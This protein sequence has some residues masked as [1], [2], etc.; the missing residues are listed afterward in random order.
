MKN[1]V[2][3][4]ILSF[5]LCIVVLEV[6]FIGWA[7]FRRTTVQ[8]PRTPISIRATRTRFPR[9]TPAS[10][11]YQFPPPSATPIRIG[12]LNIAEQGTLREKAQQ[13]LAPSPQEALAAAKKLAFA[14]INSHPSNMCGPLAIA[15][16]RDSRLLPPDT[17]LEKFWLLNP[18]QPAAKQLL[19]QYFPADR[20]EHITITT[21]LN[22]TD[23][24]LHPLYPGD[25]IYIYAGKGGN[26]EH[27]L[28][29]TRVDGFGRPYSIT[30]Y[31]TK[32]GF[33]IQERML[34]DLYNPKAGLFYEWTKKAYAKLGA[35]GFGGME[36]WRQ[37]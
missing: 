12:P 30:N 18:R 32:Q 7:L 36:I 20:Y 1:R 4:P 34:Y 6:A 33:I 10:F 21:A 8:A 24:V 26:F 22:K 5:L 13:Y 16:L 28:V 17:P 2:F 15:I 25:F 23:W 35:T 27:M 19:K 9:V 29:V 3:W 14:G 11:Q 31:A 37:K